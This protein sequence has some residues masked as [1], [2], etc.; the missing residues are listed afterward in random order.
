MPVQDTGQLHPNSNHDNSN[1]GYTWRPRGTGTGGSTRSMTAC[2]A[3]TYCGGPGKKYAQERVAQDLESRRKKVVGEPYEGKPHVRFE[4]AGHG[5]RDRAW[6]IEALP[7]ERGEKT[8]GP[9]KILDAIP[10]P[11]EATAFSAVMQRVLIKLGPLENGS[12]RKRRQ[13]NRAVRPLIKT[14]I[15]LFTTRRESH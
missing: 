3:P 12:E 14:R 10:R 2:S 15:L 1:A 4:V 9:A 7:K 6:A 8:S 13:Q 5:D 11:F